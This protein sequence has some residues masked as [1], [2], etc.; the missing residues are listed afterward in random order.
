MTRLFALAACALAAWLWRRHLAA[1]RRW[2]EWD[3]EPDLS[4]GIRDPWPDWLLERAG[5]TRT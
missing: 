3:A 5:G 2:R 4:G 1:V